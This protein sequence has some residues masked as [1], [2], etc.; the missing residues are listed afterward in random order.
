MC[1]PTA[2]SSAKLHL[3]ARRLIIPHPAGA[4]NIDVTAPLPPHMLKTWGML[5]LD[6]NRF[7]ADRD[8]DSRPAGAM[9]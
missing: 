1:W 8:D 4:A 5:G 7:D 6:P 9:L 3:H 2:A